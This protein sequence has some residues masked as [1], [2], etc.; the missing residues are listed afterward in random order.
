MDSN[1]ILSPSKVDQ[2]VQRMAYQVY[3]NNMEEEIVLIG[4]DNGGRKLAENLD[5]AL[6]D[7]FGKAFPD[8]W[9]PFHPYYC[10]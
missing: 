7:T 2:I 1:Q 6:T 5:L 3:E 8:S 4:V 9:L 10:T